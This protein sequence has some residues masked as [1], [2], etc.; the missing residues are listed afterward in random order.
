M[1]TPDYDTPEPAEATAASAGPAACARGT[2]GLGAVLGKRWG[3]ILMVFLLGVIGTMFY[4]STQ[5]KIHVARVQ[6]QLLPLGG[7]AVF[8]KG[9]AQKNANWVDTECHIITSRETLLHVVREKALAKRWDLGNDDNA[10]A[11]KLAKMVEVSREPNTDL[12]TI[13]VYTGLMD[14]AAEL[15]NAVADAY[16]ERAKEFEK[17]R[18]EAA[19]NMLQAEL[20]NQEKKV[21]EK[22]VAMLTIMKKYGI[23]DFAATKG[24]FEDGST[25][26]QNGAEE[27]LRTNKALLAAYD[28]EV[29]KLGA[30]SKVLGEIKDPVQFATVVIGLN[31]E[32]DALKQLLTKYRQLKAAPATAEMATQLEAVSKDLALEVDAA[33]QVMAAKIEIA[34][35]GMEHVTQA[36]QEEEM[37]AVGGKARQSEYLM[38]KREYEQ[39]FALLNEMREHI[40]KQK[41]DLE[42]PMLAARRHESA[43]PSPKIVRPEGEK[44]LAIGSSIALMLG[45]ALAFILEYCRSEPSEFTAQSS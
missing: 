27:G 1:D 21:E 26:I 14:V 17:G 28:Q 4:I 36:V 23:I 3:V 37:E 9:L 18:A 11:D 10:A 24:R 39:Q 33:K 38:V 42:M 44:L 8:A 13:E 40:L 16:E 29:T 30:M 5:E 31:Q 34:R 22:R 15:A 35:A 20:D 25:G 41:V 45:L 43:Y 2:R 32:A 6:L 7:A 12:V 19:V